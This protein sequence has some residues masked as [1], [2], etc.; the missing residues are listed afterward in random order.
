MREMMYGLLV[1]DSLTGSTIFSGKQCVESICERIYN[2]QI[3]PFGHKT[4]RRGFLWEGTQ[5]IFEFVAF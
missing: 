3:L 5:I 2:D 1:Y 4:D